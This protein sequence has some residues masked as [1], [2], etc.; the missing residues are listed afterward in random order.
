MAKHT[1]ECELNWEMGDN[2]TCTCGADAQQEALD[3]RKQLAALQAEN[4]KLR[5]DWRAMREAW[6]A[7]V[8]AITQLCEDADEHD[9]LHDYVTVDRVLYENLTAAL[10]KA[11]VE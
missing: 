5:A 7:M 2:A 4:A 1:Y 3:V 6:E 11:R 10:A 9:L 8:E